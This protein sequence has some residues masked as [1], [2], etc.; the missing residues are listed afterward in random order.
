MNQ[1]QAQHFYCLKSERT[2]SGS[3]LNSQL[4]YEDSLFLCTKDLK[5]ARPHG[6]VGNCRVR[7]FND[8]LAY[9]LIVERPFIQS[10]RSNAIIVHHAR[11]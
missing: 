6:V 3:V 4:I 1:F 8:E 10:I 11:G 7:I 5:V 2:V 9:R